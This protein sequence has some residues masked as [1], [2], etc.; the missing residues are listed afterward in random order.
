MN[1]ST[2]TRP[3]RPGRAPAPAS[4]YA[5][6][7]G[8]LFALSACGDATGPA[9]NPGERCGSDD[10]AVTAFADPALETEVRAAL[11]LAPEEPLTCRRAA[12]LETLGANAHGIRN[13]SG[14]EN[15]TGLTEL[16]LAQNA[17]E[18]L[19]PLSG[20]SSLE[21]LDVREN[22]IADLS[23]LVG[24][25]GMLNLS[26]AHNDISDLSPVRNMS[27]LEQLGVSHNRIADLTPVA[28]LEALLRLE[29]YNNQITDLSPLAGMWT[30]QTLDL[31]RN[32]V[33]DLSPLAEL[34]NLLIVG[35]E[36][37]SVTDL[38]P[39]RNM[40][41]LSFLVFDD[42]RGL[43][44]I[45]PLL[46]NPGVGRDDTVYLE[47]TSVSCEDIE[48]LRAKRATVTSNCP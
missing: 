21:S 22:S 43:S 8:T 40:L 11:D 36:Q 20:L 25:T 15:L 32:T 24:L 35:L 26:L 13:L 18:D 19:S 37:T 12:S 42:N 41:L 48:L 6:A 28:G 45:Q 5:W 46:D 9:L 33:P 10:N 14:I 1:E 38:S 2:Q 44:D 31:G 47:R 3:R 34:D 30:L 29:A 23:P 27:E 39:L 7:V 4:G 17:I 16:L